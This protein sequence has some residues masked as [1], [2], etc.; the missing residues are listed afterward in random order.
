M[1]IEESLKS[2]VGNCIDFEND[3]SK[4]NKRNEGE[5]RLHY[6]LIK[7]NRNFLYKSLEDISE[8]V[9]LVQLMHSLINVNHTISVVGTLIFDSNYG[10]AIVLNRASFDIIFAPS[11]GEEQGAK[12]ESVF[13]AVRY[14]YSRA[15][16]KKDSCDVLVRTQL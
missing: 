11:V 12:F 10:K 16:L 15:Q 5:S 9:T 2:D 3:I 13:T 1:C 6:N 14:I 4:D 7:Y 8:N